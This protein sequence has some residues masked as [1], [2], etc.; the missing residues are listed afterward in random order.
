MACLSDA[1]FRFRG[2]KGN[3]AQNGC[4]IARTREDVTGACSG[5]GAGGGAVALMVELVALVIRMPEG[6]PLSSCTCGNVVRL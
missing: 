3:Q 5:A 2:Q 1:A 4:I 6:A